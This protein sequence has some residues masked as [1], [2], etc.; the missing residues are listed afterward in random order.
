M[1]LTVVA[2]MLPVFLGFFCKS[3]GLFN[4]SETATLRKF[5]IK[6]SVP[7][8]IFK[9]LYTANLETIHQIL[10]SV[11]ALLIMTALCTVTAYYI[12]RYVH[13]DERV[14]NAFAFSI[15][16]ANYGYLGWG[17][18]ELF[19]GDSGLTRAVFFTLLFW[20]IF[21]VFGFALIFMR[22]KHQGADSKVFLKTLISNALLPIIAAGGGLLANHYELSFPATL[23]TFIFTFA[24]FT[25]PMILFTIGLMFTFRLKREA[26][27]VVLYGTIFRLVF[28][29]LIGILTT[30]VVSVL[31]PT[32]TLT[33]KVILLES[34]M[35]PATMVPFF[36]D[37]IATDKE[38]MSGIIT[39]ATLVSMFTIPLFYML[40]EQY[41][42]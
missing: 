13:S 31:F 32:D 9:N 18:M 27:R 35:P 39:I 1:I 36:A 14:Q 33:K 3:I 2:L 20:P 17:V 29:F 6:V 41:V 19:Y 4:D 23:Q 8:I 37:F 26:L 16:V 40:I 22:T 5:V 7:F 11:S 25:I 12:S 38:I 42:Y 21:L 34:V 30:A 24:S 10:P 15:M 28:A